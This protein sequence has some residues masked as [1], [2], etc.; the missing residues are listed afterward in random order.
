M[1]IGADTCLRVFA[2]C[3]WPHASLASA[4][5]HLRHQE[6]QLQRLLGV[7]PRV[8]RGLVAAGQVGVGDLLRAAQALG[9][10]LA[11]QL[12]VDAARVGAQLVVHLEEALHLVHD[13]VEVP[14]LVA[15]RRLVGVAVH[16]VALPDDLVPGRL[17]L[18]DDR[19]QHVPDLAV[20]H[21]GDQGEPAGLVPR[22]EPLDVL[23]RL[24]RGGARA[25]LQPDRVG[26][27]LRERDVRAVQLPGPLAHPQEVPG[28]VVQP[29][30][31]VAGVQP[32]HRPLVVQQQR[33]VRG[34]D[35]HL[36]QRVRG[37][38]RRPS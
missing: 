10:V 1:D 28:Q 4:A 18:L 25:D 3:G 14:G 12:D 37:R 22:V 8:A 27:Q 13:P 11:G 38:P 9:D 31:V 32:Q 36:V 20:A 15:G 7:Q 35:V 6:R 2:Q 29:G 16:R 5:Q 26:Q 34:E 19:R 33:L 30:L 24:L 21:P 17:H 23:D